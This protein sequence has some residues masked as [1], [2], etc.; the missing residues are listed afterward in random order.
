MKPFHL[1]ATAA[2]VLAAGMLGAGYA[3]ADD[4]TLLVIDPNVV[5]DT[6]AYSPGAVTTNPGGQPGAAKTYTHRDGRLITDTVWVLPD[7]AAATAAATAAQSTAGIA[8][9]KSEPVQVGTGGTFISGTSA[10]GSQ[11]LGLLTFTQ[12]NAASSIAFSGPANDP[13]DATLATEL[14][15]A[16]VALIKSRMGG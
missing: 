15:Q 1:A 12:G 13:P 6:L 16:Q 11:A 5:V 10:D 14:G 4:Y 2:A 9:P 8:N 7:A 3:S